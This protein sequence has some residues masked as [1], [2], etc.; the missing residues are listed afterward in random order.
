V[1]KSAHSNEL[2]ERVRYAVQHCS[3]VHILATSALWHYAVLVRTSNLYL[4]VYT[5]HTALLYTHTQSNTQAV[6]ALAAAAV[7]AV[8]G[9]A[10]VLVLSDL[11][12]Q[13]SSSAAEGVTSG[14]TYIPPLLA[15]GAVHH[16]LIGRGLRMDAS[17][18]RV[19][20]CIV[21]LC[22]ETLT[23]VSAVSGI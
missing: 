11:L 1:F 13:S 6:K 15:V 22:N 18:V 21:M 2:V 19:T 16:E 20:L 9:G 12:A 14:T 7:A 4:T 10:E 5:L 8:E 3:T 23:S 17:L